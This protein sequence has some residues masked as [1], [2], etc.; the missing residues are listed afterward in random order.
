MGPPGVAK[1]RLLGIGTPGKLYRFL[2]YRYRGAHGAL[3]G[4]YTTPDQPTL[5]GPLVH[6]RGGRGRL[7]LWGLAVSKWAA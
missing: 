1:S 3:C 7:E 6:E 4:A 2:A 5:V